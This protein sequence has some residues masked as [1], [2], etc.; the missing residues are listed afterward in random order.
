MILT[1]YKERTYHRNDVYLYIDDAREK[2]EKPPKQNRAINL[3][4]NNTYGYFRVQQ[5]SARTCS[6]HR[7]TSG[8][9]IVKG[10]SEWL[11]ATSEAYGVPHPQNTVLKGVPPASCQPDQQSGRVGIYRNY[12]QNFSHCCS[13]PTLPPQR[14][15]HQFL[16]VLPYI[17]AG[18]SC[19]LNEQ[20]CRKNR[21]LL[22]SR[23]A[24]KSCLPTSPF[25]FKICIPTLNHKRI[26]SHE[27][28]R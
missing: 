8:E 18:L 12:N 21:I 2:G 1:P 24:F 17:M 22:Q 16:S 9:R 11:C 15:P 23:V 10:F 27:H 25:N 19:M 5:Q 20:G 4:R 13:S 26:F 7:G 28:W 6:S 3:A 14:K